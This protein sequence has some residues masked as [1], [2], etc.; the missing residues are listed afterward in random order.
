MAGGG[1]GMIGRPDLGAFQMV[2]EQRQGAIEDLRGV[3][4]GQRVTHQVLHTPQAIVRLMS[5][6]DL[7]S[8]ALGRDSLHRSGLR[9]R[10]PIFSRGLPNGVNRRERFGR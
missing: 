4:A 6:G 10:C 8:I 9:R 1:P 5:H 3:A 7:D 2:E